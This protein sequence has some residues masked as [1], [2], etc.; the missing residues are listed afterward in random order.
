MIPELHTMP[1]TFV[2]ESRRVCAIAMYRD[3]SLLSSALSIT[4]RQLFYFIYRLIMLATL[5]STLIIYFVQPLDKQ[6]KQGPFRRMR[7]NIVTQTPKKDTKPNLYWRP[8]RP[9]VKTTCIGTTVQLCCRTEK[10]VLRP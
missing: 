2:P 6:R 5:I 1:L 9:R 8:Y 10:A 4:L 3:T 7:F